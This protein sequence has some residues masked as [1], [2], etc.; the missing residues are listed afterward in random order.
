[1]KSD[2]I[3]GLGTNKIIGEDGGAEVS[4]SRFQT[5]ASVAVIQSS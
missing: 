2:L 4:V 1:M 3:H 5:F